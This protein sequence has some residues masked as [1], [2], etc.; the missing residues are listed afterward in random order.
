MV[1]ERSLRRSSLLVMVVVDTVVM[2]CLP[3]CCYAW[4]GKTNDGRAALDQ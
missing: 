1:P 3:G 2:L 4:H